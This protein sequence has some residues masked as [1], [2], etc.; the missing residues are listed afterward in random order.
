[1]RRVRPLSIILCTRPLPLQRGQQS[2]LVPLLEAA[3]HRVAEVNDGELNFDG[4]NVVWILGNANWFPHVCRQLMATAQRARPFV[5]IGH[6]EPLPPPRASGLSWPWLHVREAAKIVLRDARAT[7]VYSN[8]F[9]LRQLARHRIPDLLLMPSPAWIEFLAE[10]GV[11]AHWLPFA[12]DPSYGRDLGLQRDVEVLFL[13][14]LDV[15]RRRRIIR[16]LRRAGINLVAMGSWS[17]PACWGDNRTRLLNR[18]KI[19]LNLPRSSGELAGQRLALGMANKALVISEPIYKP[20]PYVPGTHYVS[21]TVADMPA[22]IRYYL[23][24]D[25]E[26]D[27]I[28]DAAYR[29]VTRE[30]TATASV[31]RVL[32]L[33]G[34]HERFGADV[35]NASPRGASA[36]PHTEARS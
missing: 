19:L 22:A 34:A 16:R 36:S 13:G 20:A 5:I 17:D 18:T 3:G 6:G 33:I 14:A 35:G 12:Y 10:R 2:L 7:D 30:M 26:R 11:H 28:V 25:A 32:S 1:M 8:Y 29:F 24:H 4:T 21:A 27:R 9:R 15:P 23:T 31:D